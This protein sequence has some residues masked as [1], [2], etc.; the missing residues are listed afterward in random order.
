MAALCICSHSR[1]P[2]HGQTTDVNRVWVAVNGFWDT[3]TQRPDYANMQGHV[4]AAHT[5]FFDS[6]ELSVD[7]NLLCE[8]GCVRERIPFHLQPSISPFWP[9]IGA[10]RFT[11]PLP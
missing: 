2:G 9:W 7:F 6:W 8:E 5:L 11:Q 1:G 10:T 4:R 3:R